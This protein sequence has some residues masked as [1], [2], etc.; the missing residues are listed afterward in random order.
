MGVLV[1]LFIIYTGV[2]L[3][4]IQLIHCLAWH[5]QRNGRRHYRKIL[6]YEGIIDRM[7][8][9]YTTMASR[10]FASVH[11]EVPASQ[12]IMQSHDIIDNIERD[13]LKEQGIHMVIHLDPVVTDDEKT[14]ELRQQVE[15]IVAEVAPEL[16][17]HDFRVVWG[18]SHTNLIFDV[19]I[20]YGL[21]RDDGEIVS[22]ITAM[23]Y[24]LNPTYNS[25]ITVDHHY[26]P[27]TVEISCKKG[28]G[29]E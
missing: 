29:E 28:G 21:D 11:C 23:V 5:H 27:D 6:S 1:A 2:K 12:D 19:V 24:Q 13:F 22:K 26:V 10:R 17:M 18:V 16:S 15:K 3:V 7:T 14:N 20:P 9:G 8:C 4:R 25:V